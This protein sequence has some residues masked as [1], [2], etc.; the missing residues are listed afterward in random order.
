ME[1]IVVVE[2]QMVVLPYS[3]AEEVNDPQSLI[4]DGTQDPKIPAIGEVEN[5]VEEDRHPNED[6][7]PKKKRRGVGLRWIYTKT[8]PT[9]ENALEEFS[10][11]NLIQNEQTMGRK[12]KGVS[13]TVHY[14]NCKKARCGC[15][16]SWRMVITEA[17]EEV[18]LEE[19]F[20]D[21][22]KHDQFQRHGGKG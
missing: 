2:D 20:V 14:I 15:E 16:K 12:T 4:P 18:V 5:V 11:A 8:F 22:S 13:T 19:T 21:H 9:K 10:K 7:N 17:S 3:P 6:G 1:D